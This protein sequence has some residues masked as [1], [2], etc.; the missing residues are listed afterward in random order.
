MTPM[1]GRAPARH[2]DRRRVSAED[3]PAISRGGL[4]HIG[5]GSIFRQPAAFIVR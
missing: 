4:L 3:D 5:L 1:H 2:I